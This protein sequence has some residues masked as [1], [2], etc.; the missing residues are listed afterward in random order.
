MLSQ[1]ASVKVVDVEGRN[2]VDFA[3]DFFNEDVV[4]EILE[5]ENWKDAMK[6]AIARPD[7]DY[8]VIT[9][10]RKLIQSMPD[11]AKLVLN[12]C[13]EIRPSKDVEKEADKHTTERWHPLQDVA[14]K[15]LESAGLDIRFNYDF[16]DDDYVMGIENWK[17]LSIEQEP[18][19]PNAFQKC[20]NGFTKCCK[21]MCFSSKKKEDDIPRPYDKTSRA[22]IK[23]H[24]LSYM[25]DYEREDLINHP[26]V[27]RL[28]TTKWRSFGSW[29]YGTNLTIYVLFMVPC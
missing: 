3:I 1:S 10:M 12:R 27:T 2:A 21:R 13:M 23:N 29:V 11:M 6:N 26:L 28:Y 18:E 17:K 19:K 22:L 8:P 9:P 25:V 15:T 20:V 24:P 14:R 7:P 16:M 5:S 4:G